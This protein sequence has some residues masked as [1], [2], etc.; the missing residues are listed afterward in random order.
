MLQKMLCVAA[1]ILML[2]GCAEKEPN[3]PDVLVP[4]VMVEG[5]VY[6]TTGEE[7]PGEVEE[8]ALLGKVSSVRAAQPMAGKGGRGQLRRNRRAL[9]LGRRTGL[10]CWSIRNGRCLRPKSKRKKAL[11]LP[12]NCK[13]SAFCFFSCPSVPDR[14]RAPAR[15]SCAASAFLPRRRA[16]ARCTS[17]CARDGGRACGF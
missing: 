10:S 14:A 12:G 16:P 2:S 15:N 7:F 17:G 11:S 3:T 4:A 8:S 9:C 5:Q 1:A 13:D 6:C